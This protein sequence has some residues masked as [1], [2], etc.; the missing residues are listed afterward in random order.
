MLKQE[1]ER[2]SAVFL[3]TKMSKNVS[4]VGKEQN[5]I[6][7]HRYRREMFNHYRNLQQPGVKNYL[8]I[9]FGQFPAKVPFDKKS[10]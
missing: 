3:Q 1:M 9:P 10:F 2:A 7:L 8:L 6:C 4:T 5:K